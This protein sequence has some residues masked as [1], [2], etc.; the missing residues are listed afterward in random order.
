[1]KDPQTVTA[2][3]HVTRV[4]TRSPQRWRTRLLASALAVGAC[5]LLSGAARASAQVI[6]PPPLKP[7]AASKSGTAA[8][9]KAGRFRVTLNGFFVN[10]QTVDHALEVDGKGDEVYCVADVRLLNRAGDVLLRQRRQSAVFGDTNG[11]PDRRRAG[12]ASDRGGL[13]SGDA[14]P[15]AEPWRRDP[16]AVVDDGVGRRLNLPMLLWEGELAEG[17]NLLKVLP[18]V[19]EWD[20]NPELFGQWNRTYEARAASDRYDFGYLIDSITNPVVGRTIGNYG[21]QRQ[22]Q[23]LDFKFN[24]GTAGDRPIGSV[25]L[26]GTDV[27]VFNPL[28]LYLN[29]AAAAVASRNTG[30]IEV[31]YREPSPSHLEGDYTLYLQ[32]ER[33]P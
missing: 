24:L 28:V 10:H 22:R 18:M 9:R 3:S 32:V 16:D 23:P 21:T 19:W 2:R 29:Y 27:D 1:M 14:Y 33:L 6:H 12:S 4:R 11:F 25:Q 30:G 13:K 15:H 5:A 26:D 17:E 20:N 31:H 7:P 8:A